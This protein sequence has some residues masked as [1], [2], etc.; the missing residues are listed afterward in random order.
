MTLVPAGALVVSLAAL[1]AS[2]AFNVWQFFDRRAARRPRV[3]LDVNPVPGSPS[4][5]DRR[6]GALTGGEASA[7]FLAGTIH[8]A[9]SAVLTDVRLAPATGRPRR[10]AWKRMPAPDVYVGDPAQPDSGRRESGMGIA[11]IPDEHTAH[12]LPQPLTDAQLVIRVE[13]PEPLPASLNRHQ[14]ARLW[15]ETDTGHR[16]LS[17]VGE[18]HN[19]YRGPRPAMGAAE[20]PPFAHELTG[21]PPASGESTE[22]LG[23]EHADR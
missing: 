20:R 18:F 21:P 1:V 12:R 5:P 19:R 22:L 11:Q 6:E 8:V 15:V 23:P 13:Y 4:W 2:V 3:Y 17:P 9:G 16:F 14:G 7:L 10:S